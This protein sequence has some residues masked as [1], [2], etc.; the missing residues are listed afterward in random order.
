MSTPSQRAAAKSPLAAL[1]KTNAALRK[2]AKGL[3]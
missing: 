2:E 1:E 3:K